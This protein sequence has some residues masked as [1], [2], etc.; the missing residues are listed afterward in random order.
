MN[1]KNF[2]A[3]SLFAS[4][5]LFAILLTT[6]PVSAQGDLIPISDVNGG[7]G[8]FVLR[9]AAKGPPK[10]VLPSRASR[11]KEQ[12]IATARKVSKQYT[13]LAKVAPRRTRTDAVDPN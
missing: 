12:R 13:T 5:V 4:L 6:I 10:R 1:T 7:A 11:S 2:F 8:I 3:R 9:G